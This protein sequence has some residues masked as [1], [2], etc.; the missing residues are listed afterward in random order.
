MINFPLF[1][2]QFMDNRIHIIFCILLMPI[3]V[4]AQLPKCDLYLL[5]LRQ[6]G[7]I[8]NISYLTDYNPGKYNNQPFFISENEIL[9]ASQ[10][11]DDQTDVVLLNLEKST[12]K[13]LTKTKESE[14]SPQ[15]YASSTFTVVRV[16]NDGSQVL[17]EYPMNLKDIGKK[18]ISDD[19]QIGYYLHLPN[20]K[21]ALFTIEEDEFDLII[22]DT[23]SGRVKKVASDIG[24]SFDQSKTG[25][26]YFL[27][28]TTPNSFRI[29]KYNTI[30]NSVSD[31]TDA[32]PDSQ[33]FCI[34]GSEE[35]ILMASGSQIFR[36][37]SSNSSWL[38]WKDLSTYGINNITRLC[39][40]NDQLIIVNNK[41]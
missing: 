32:L 13:R 19:F 28:K 26:L 2:K 16:E 4:F 36:Y 1:N 7:E 25:E 24:R 12:F 10:L 40:K 15:S 23:R 9:V 18:L 6:N 35:N 21:T 29:K 39:A 17:W 33:D 8:K 27:N 38:L 22:A 31:I 20:F 5:D 30:N 41:Q 34:W 14:Y 3:L 11:K 37:S